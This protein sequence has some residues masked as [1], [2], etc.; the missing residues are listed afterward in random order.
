MQLLDEKFLPV[1]G[2][3]K[4]ELVNI[5]FSDADEIRTLS[6]FEVPAKNLC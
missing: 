5:F 1:G 6:P 3:Q 2:R 4:K